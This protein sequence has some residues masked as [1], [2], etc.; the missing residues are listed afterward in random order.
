MKIIIL[1]VFFLQCLT[2]QSI[3]D[4]YQKKTFVSDSDT[5]NYRIY[6]PKN[7]NPNHQYPLILFLH[8]SGERGY[9]NE[10]QLTHGAAIFAND[11]IQNKF[12]SIVVFPQCP[13]KDYWVNLVRDTS[14]SQFE[15]Q[16]GGLPTKALSMVMLLMEKLSKQAFI[17][18]KQIYVGGLSMG[19]MGTFEILAR[20]PHF[21]AAAFAICGAAHP[22][23]VKQFANLTPV[24]IFH[25][26]KDNVVYPI[27]S[28]QVV[29]TILN[30]GG[31]PNFTLYAKD[32]HNSWDS[33]FA[34]PNL[35]NWLFSN[36][37]KQNHKP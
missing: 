37:N 4:L 19:G 24:W 34:E 22:K 21:F 2:A 26:A 10:K 3:N 9:D 20:K 13:T 12:P 7:F 14:P 29:E 6:Y 28:L 1:F 8:G 33:A 16:N 18:T 15:F 5:L 35:F 23:T 36:Q 31:T 25:G 30:E 27:N 32:N 17:N 11:S